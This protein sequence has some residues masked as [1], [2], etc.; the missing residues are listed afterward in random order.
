MSIN[1]V[2]YRL[3]CVLFDS[4]SAHLFIDTLFLFIIIIIIIYFSMF[5]SSHLA[6]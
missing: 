5:T 6:N 1:E 3:I 2:K 4:P